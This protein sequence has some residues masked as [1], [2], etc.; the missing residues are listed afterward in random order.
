MM[1]VM[2]L[3]RKHARDLDVCSPFVLA[4]GIGRWR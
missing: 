1:I 4:F 3:E 2:V